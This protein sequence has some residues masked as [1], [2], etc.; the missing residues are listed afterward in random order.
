MIE[1]MV[2]AYCNSHGVELGDETKPSTVS[3]KI[4]AGK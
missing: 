1:V 2:V 4:K 3:V